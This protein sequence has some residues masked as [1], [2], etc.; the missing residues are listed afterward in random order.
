MCNSRQKSGGVVMGEMSWDGWD[1][2]ADIVVVGSGAAAASA[3][4]TAA[5]QGA[6]VIVLE[7]AA[8]TGGTRG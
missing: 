4:V 5:A 8:F 7:K 6:S 3:A 1:E 2:V